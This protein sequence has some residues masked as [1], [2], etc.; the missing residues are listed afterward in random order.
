MK[1]NWKTEFKYAGILVFAL[2][3]LYLIIHI[4]VPI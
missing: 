4:F 1:I 2:I 3:I